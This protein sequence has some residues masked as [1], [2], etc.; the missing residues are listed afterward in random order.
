METED[1]HAEDGEAAETHVGR[2]ALLKRVAITLGGLT[3]GGA[4]AASLADA[5]HKHAPSHSS[6]GLSARDREI[7]EFALRLEHL[8]VA[9]YAEALK[10]GK[11]TGE[12]KQF[13]Q[14]VGKEEHAHL[15]YVEKALKQPNSKPA[16][17][18]FGDATA[19]DKAFVKAAAKIEDT[20][21][22][23][24]NGQAE[25]LS[26]HMLQD[27]ARVIS[28]E[29]RHAAWARSLAGQ[30]PAPVPA[31]QPISAAQALNAIKPYLA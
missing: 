13:A 26:R 14:I 2:G 7:L 24:Y 23:A 20:G 28:V 6:G 27:V 5:S 10:R 11:L 29:A 12:A 30:L 1:L 16:K 4:A 17:Y 9:F 19:S 8:Q 25:N 21:I 15:A 31:D 22:A 3:A 18:K